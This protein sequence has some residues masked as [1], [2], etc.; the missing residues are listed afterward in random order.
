[1]KR[2]NFSLYFIFIAF[3]SFLAIFISIVQ[4]SYKNL[5]KPVDKIKSEKI[6]PLNL[7]LDTEIISQI[8]SREEIFVAPTPEP[9]VE[10]LL[11]EVVSP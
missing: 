11:E 4:N 9:T 5:V 7:N 1:M 8:E 3:F 10:P 2:N 6:E